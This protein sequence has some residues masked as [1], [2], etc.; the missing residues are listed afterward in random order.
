M[1]LTIPRPPRSRGGVIDPQ[2]MERW[3]TS[4]WLAINGAV[5]SGGS[6]TQQTSRST[7]VLLNSLG[8]DIVMFSSSVAAG[9]VSTFT[10]TNKAILPTDL[11]L[12]GHISA[13][14]GGAWGVS[15][16]PGTGSCTISV[17]NLTA[18]AITSAT[19]LRFTL[20]KRVVV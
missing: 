7:G 11:I 19:P 17:R 14:N 18:A 5:G 4:V 16:V 9:G 20:I 10:L 13:T 3:L 2:E 15:A 8:G 12:I 1:S 6:V